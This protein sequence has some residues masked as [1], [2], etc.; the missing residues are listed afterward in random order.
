M[1][2][3][4]HMSAGLFCLMF[5]ASAVAAEERWAIL[6]GPSAP[7]LERE[8]GQELQKSFT[9]LFGVRPSLPNSSSDSAQFLILVGTP[10]T[11]PAVKAAT[12]GDWPALSEQGFVLR[13]TKLGKRSA[14]IVGGG[15]PV[16]TLW[17]AYDLLEHGL[18]MAGLAP[19]HGTQA[20]DR[21]VVAAPGQP[22]GHGGNLAGPWDPHNHDL[23]I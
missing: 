21:H 3:V 9:K 17:A 14:L 18:I 20:E 11:N 6:V 7:A 19:D 23:I 13:K 22:P 12:K 4:R 10:A 8:A 2:H 5:F 16:A 15:S 1:K